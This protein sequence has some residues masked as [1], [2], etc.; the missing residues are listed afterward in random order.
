MPVLGIS[1][2]KHINLLKLADQI[3]NDINVFPWLTF[4]THCSSGGSQS[5][6]CINIIIIMETQ[7]T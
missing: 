5:S 1:G 4:G 6:P 7:K 2:K 3:S